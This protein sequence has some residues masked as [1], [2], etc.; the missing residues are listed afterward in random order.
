M[1]SMISNNLAIHRSMPCR[2][3][4]VVSSI[5][6]IRDK[7]KDGMLGMTRDKERDKVKTN[8]SKAKVRNSTSQVKAG[9]ASVGD[10][11]MAMMATAEIRFLEK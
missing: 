6:R 11:S 10:L 9:E 3:V 4:M 7:I 5:I 1:T 2:R 8:I